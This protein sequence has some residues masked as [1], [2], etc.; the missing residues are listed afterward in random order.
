MK[1]SGVC[2]SKR[3]LSRRVSSKVS[4]DACTG[5]DSQYYFYINFNFCLVIFYICI[6]VCFLPRNIC[7]GE[8]LSCESA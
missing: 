8:D 1:G 2:R 4:F 5:G 3:G 6:L 7:M